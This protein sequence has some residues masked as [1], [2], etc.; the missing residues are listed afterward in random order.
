M[1]P[2]LVHLLCAHLSHGRDCNLPMGKVDGS[3]IGCFGLAIPV[4]GYSLFRG[5]DRRWHLSCGADL[6]HHVHL[7]HTNRFLPLLH[8]LPDPDPLAC[9]L[10][11][12]VII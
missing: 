10:R 2:R 9:F 11:L 6:S 5:Q 3:C 12:L 4:S 8:V 7:V 1:C